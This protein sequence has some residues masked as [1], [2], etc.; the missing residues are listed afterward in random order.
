M[1]FMKE[2]TNSDYIP[3]FTFHIFINGPLTKD[4]PPKKKKQSAMYCIL[5]Y[6]NIII[7]YI[8][9]LDIYIFKWYII[10]FSSPVETWRWGRA[11]TELRAASAAAA[12]CWEQHRRIP[13]PPS[14]S[15]ATWGRQGQGMCRERW[16]HWSTESLIARLSPWWV[17]AQ[18]CHLSVSAKASSATSTVANHDNSGWQQK[19]RSYDSHT[20]KKK[21]YT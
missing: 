20:F 13:D 8:F 17:I 16:K 5:Y 11:C 9:I 14:G 10:P 18:D 3:R 4:H 12:H 1:L 21:N 7:V 15:A 6:Q 19:Q 2:R